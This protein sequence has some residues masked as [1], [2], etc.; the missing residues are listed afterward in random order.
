MTTSSACRWIRSQPLWYSGRRHRRSPRL[1]HFKEEMLTSITLASLSTWPQPA[2]LIF[3]LCL[4]RGRSCFLGGCDSFRWWLCF[5]LQQNGV[6]IE[7]AWTK[8]SCSIDT[9]TTLAK[10]FIDSDLA[11]LRQWITYESCRSS[12]SPW[13][14]RTKENMLV[15]VPHQPF[16]LPGWG[17]SCRWRLGV[18]AADVTSRKRRGSVRPGRCSSNLLL[19]G[20][21]HA[22]VYHF[23]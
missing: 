7:S 22:M 4:F 18:R 10:G 15:D 1:L 21:H 2:S 23:L 12:R 17:R 6:G 11:Q 13:W 3:W 19:V 5:Q 20:I 14:H 9:N 8:Q 16:H